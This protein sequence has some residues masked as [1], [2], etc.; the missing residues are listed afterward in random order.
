[1]L[2]YR[3]EDAERAKGDD[4]EAESTE[5]DG[6]SADQEVTD[7]VTSATSAEAA[8]GATSADAGT[9]KATDETGAVSESAEEEEMRPV[10]EGATGTA[11]PPRHL[12]AGMHGGTYCKRDRENEDNQSRQANEKP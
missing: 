8:T 12:G 1:M 4:G 7:A 11:Q 6:G 10:E 9:G 3:E 5:T 2:R